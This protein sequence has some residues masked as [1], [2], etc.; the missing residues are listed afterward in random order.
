MV[1]YCAQATDILILDSE[2]Q[3]LR[4]AVLKAAEGLARVGHCV[5]AGRCWTLQDGV[6]SPICYFQCVDGA[7]R[8]GGTY[9]GQQFPTNTST[10]GNT[11]SLIELYFKELR[12]C[13]G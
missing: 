12:R 11:M 9:Y 10:S 6:I 8:L 13:M 4:I 7:L 1:A 3:S 5:W 2:I